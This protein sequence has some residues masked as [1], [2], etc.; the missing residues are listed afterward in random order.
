MLP[1]YDAKLT[2]YRSK[3][4]HIQRGLRHSDGAHVVIKGYYDANIPPEVAGRLR[5]EYKILSLLAR[6]G[7]RHVV[8]PLAL[9]DTSAQVAIVL[10]DIEG[11]SLRICAA[12]MPL[13]LQEV[14]HVGAQIA[15]ALHDGHAARVV[16][17]DINPA[18]IVFNRESGVVQLID[19]GISA[20]VTQELQNVESLRSM[21]GTLPYVSPEQTGRT[22]RL[23][24]YRSDFYSL[25]VTLYELIGGRLPFA[26]EDATELV[27][28]ILARIPKPLESLTPS[29]P[30]VVCEIISKLMEKMP[31][32]RYQSASVLADDLQRCLREVQTPQGLTSFAIAQADRS[33]LFEIPQKLYGR[34]GDVQTLLRAYERVTRGAGELVL[35][36]GSSGIGKSALVNALQRVLVEHRAAFLPGKYDQLRRHVPFSAFGQAISALVRRIL[37]ESEPEIA[38]WRRLVQDVMGKV[39]QALVD[40]VPT[41]EQLVGKQKPLVALGPQETENRLL[42]LLSRF[43][44]AVCAKQPVVL[45]L[46]DL[47]W[48][49]T[50]T[51]RFL[52]MLCSDAQARAGL[53]LIGAYRDNEITRAHPLN[54]ILEALRALPLQQADIVMR[55]LQLTDINEMLEDATAQADTVIAPLAKLIHA[56]TAGNPFFVHTFLKY[57]WDKHLLVYNAQEQTW[58]W[59]QQAI[60]VSAVSD[61]VVALVTEGLRRLAPKELDMLG[62]AACLGSQFS[63]QTLAQVTSLP[64]TQVATLLDPAITA[65]VVMP[66]SGNYRYATDTQVNTTYKF[67]HDRVHQAA[68]GALSPEKAQRMRYTI[69]QR[70]LEQCDM[71]QPGTWVFTVIDHLNHSASLVEDPEEKLRLVHLNLVAADESRKAIAYNVA[72]DYLENAR[73]LMPAD[74]WET[75][76]ERMRQ[77]NLDLAAN[78]FLSGDLE[79]ATVGLDDVLQRSRTPAERAAVQHR[80]MLALTALGRFKDAVQVG[81]EA[82]RLL[83]HDIDAKPSMFGLGIAVIKMRL[84]LLGK[85]KTQ[86]AKMPLCEDPHMLQCYTILT[87]M[88]MAAYFY[89]HIFFAQV[90]MH[91]AYLTVRHGL[92]VHSAFAFIVYVVVL[93]RLSDFKDLWT[94]VKVSRECEERLPNSVAPGAIIFIR[95]A[96]VDVMM[97]QPRELSSKYEAAVLACIEDGDPLYSS[98]AAS[99]TVCYL[100]F[101]SLPGFLEA[102]VQHQDFVKPRNLAAYKLMLCE[103][104]AALCQVGRT[105]AADSFDDARFSSA[106]QEAEFAQDRLG[107]AGGWY[108]TMRA[109]CLWMHRD[110]NAAA[111]AARRA[112]DYE[113]MELCSENRFA[114]FYLAL[115]FVGE[116]SVHP[117]GRIRSKRRLRSILRR[118]RRVATMSPKVF[119]GAPVLIEAEMAALRGRD[120]Q[121]IIL[122]EDAVA[123]MAECGY[124]SLLAAALECAG[125]F[126]ANRKMHTAAQ[127]FLVRAYEAYGQ[128]GATVKV[129]SLVSEFPMYIKSARTAF[130]TTPSLPITRLHE[131]ATTSKKAISAFDLPAVLRACQALSGET[132][133]EKLLGLI[134]SSLIQCAGATRAVLLS[135]DA[136]KH[137]HI[138]IDSDQEMHDLPHEAVQ[139]V[140][141]S[142]EVLVADSG[143]NHAKVQND[144]YLQR[145][146]PK[147]M[148]CDPIV[149]QGQ[150]KGVIYL[151][152]IYTS[153]VFSADKLVSVRLLAT[154]ALIS[155]ENAQLLEHLEETVS[156]RTREVDAA[157]QRLIKLERE[158]TEVRMAGGFA[159]EMR[160]ALSAASM[161]LES[162]EL[163]NSKVVDMDPATLTTAL[164]LVN[165]SVKR[166]LHIVLQVLTYA[167]VSEGNRGNDKVDLA[168]LV[169]EVTQELQIKLANVDVVAHVPEAL[170]WPLKRDHAYTIVRNLLSNASDAVTSSGRP[171]G[172]RQTIAVQVT[173]ADQCIALEV[174]DT[175]S[176]I[177]AQVASHIFQPF[178]ST[179]GA[180]GSGLGLGVTRKLAELYG[181]SVVFSSE[182]EQ[183]ATF[184]VR[185]PVE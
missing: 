155:L 16:H 12:Q 179:K 62:M 142:Q 13:T 181:G 176:G 127:A 146:Q 151:E 74:G 10:E 129:A 18:N 153:D 80:R 138:E 100:G 126:C 72:I 122:Y 19:Y 108:Y 172:T 173:V 3:A 84:A 114:G 177:S 175:G 182:P 178:F 86:L 91:L 154:Q 149:L 120:A 157:H 89:H 34:A 38:R 104:R 32:R 7:A 66:L 49:D 47:Q 2:L 15:L 44:R 156:E 166:G 59:D 140:I 136:N 24:D 161:V 57:L 118:L 56:K 48:A 61:N 119:A 42:T 41:M 105:I 78:R 53:L 28:A 103:Q 85:D 31:E 128:W 65:G 145:V 55:P 171:H 144:P 109:L 115:A 33:E 160:N 50:G 67:V 130:E 90:C 5:Y 54:A 52:V 113:V 51:L 76:Y 79:R 8:R 170:R 141:R 68:Y 6:A 169:A 139:Y 1:G 183:G 14:L 58:T 180:G 111:D 4:S 11:Q 163:P 148:M 121:A 29:V 185:I 101:V 36:A 43:M 93:D 158:S 25:G 46:D 77:I 17:K 20:H 162:L 98:W 95:A 23:L 75:Q 82:L 143:G 22:N 37:M 110:M 35:V 106:A 69:S 168:K 30:P 134:V 64:A 167:E 97:V 117:Q 102:M 164:S 87:D 88:I 152:N 135:L 137:P 165:Q 39:G 107:P 184:V 81:T 96:Y 21:E 132:S 60:E 73:A 92:S 174:R 116:A 112:I 147:A 99:L 123:K 124:P 63:L 133:T 40:I 83:D 26:F 94:F 45:F 150:I 71:S 27:H 131:T 159:H 70:L 125:R 9:C